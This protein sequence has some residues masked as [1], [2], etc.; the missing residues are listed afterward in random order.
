MGLVTP[1]ITTH[2]PPSSL[3]PSD[4]AVH[5]GA[6]SSE[7]KIRFHQ[8][9]LATNTDRD[10]VAYSQ[11]HTLQGLVRSRVSWN[12]EPKPYCRSKP[13]AK[14]GV[15]LISTLVVSLVVVLISPYRIPHSN[16]C[17][18]P[19][20]V[21][22]FATLVST[23]NVFLTPGPAI[24]AR[25][26]GRSTGAQVGKT[27]LGFWWLSECRVQH[28]ISCP[29][30]TVSGCMVCFIQTLYPEPSATQSSSLN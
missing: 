10:L 15:S 5:G 2:E 18:I 20:I 22:H 6:S 9:K 25:P 17:R 8:Q 3:Q 14:V 21:S 12:M 13:K 27:L 29:A 19:Y 24:G 30:Y 4:L 11:T 16:P 23:S 28:I 1:F 7:K 26:H